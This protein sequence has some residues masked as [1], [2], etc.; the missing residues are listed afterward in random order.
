MDFQ[1]L[2]FILPHQFR[3]KNILEQKEI[4]RNG[5]NNILVRS[6][7]DNTNEDTNTVFSPYQ[8]IPET[9]VNWLLG[10]NLRK[11]PDKKEG[12]MEAINSRLENQRLRLKAVYNSTDNGKYNEFAKDEQF[13]NEIVSARNSGKQKGAFI[14][15]TCEN[16]KSD[17]K[18]KFYP[19]VHSLLRIIGL[20]C[21]N[22]VQR[23][24]AYSLYNNHIIPAEIKSFTETPTYNLKGIRQAIEN[25]ICSY[26]Y[27]LEDDINYSSFV[28]GF[29]HPNSDNDVRNLIDLAFEKWGI[30]IIASD[31]FS[32][33]KIAVNIVWDNQLLDLK[34]FI[35][36]YGLLME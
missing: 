22:E 31:L 13:I 26:K 29:A 17:D 16:H 25:K 4:C 5:I 6:G 11:H 3:R 21:K 33:V 28:I 23:F 20:D 12:R 9:N 19:F 35:T 10:E 30:K 15:E 18:N 1:K 32:L 36:S 14:N 7:I 34:N 24:D 2:S 8:L 27:D